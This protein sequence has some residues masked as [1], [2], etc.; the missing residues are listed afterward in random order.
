MVIPEVDPSKL[1]RVCEGCVNSRMGMPLDQQNQKPEA[2]DKLG[3]LEQM[4][5][6]G[7][8][9]PEEDELDTVAP[10][11]VAFQPLNAGPAATATAPA[12]AAPATSQGNTMVAT[13]DDARPRGRSMFKDNKVMADIEKWFD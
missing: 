2:E 3:I 7:S 6:K 11:P 8:R 9:K 5:A 13:G 12:A 10:L 1:S 4:V